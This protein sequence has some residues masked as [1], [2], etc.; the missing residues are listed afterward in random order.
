MA[1]KLPAK[2]AYWSV[3][4]ILP[5]AQAANRAIQQE[6]KEHFAELSTAA[7]MHLRIGSSTF[8]CTYVLPA[9][10]QAFHE[11]Y[12]QVTFSFTER[13]TAEL[14]EGLKNGELDLLLEAECTDNPMFCSEAF[15]TEEIVLAVPSEHPINQKISGYGYTFEEFLRRNQPNGCKPAIPLSVFNQEGFIMLTKDN[16]LYSR[17]LSICKNASF[18]PKT[19]FS[20]YQMIT[21]YNLVC[22]GVGISFLRSTIPGYVSPTDQIMFYQLDDPLA[23]R[24]IY[25]TRLQKRSSKIQQALFDFLIEHRV[26][27]EKS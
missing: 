15:A 4:R 25:L 6:T 8:F 23:V 19:L 11:L 5:P 2:G 16:D 13:R 7:G 14:F 12:P 3:R 9:L 24:S 22:D 10:L 26:C 21:A 20:V 17:I 1:G 18:C 27:P